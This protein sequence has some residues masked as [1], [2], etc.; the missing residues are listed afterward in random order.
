MF[1]RDRVD[2]RS[3]SLALPPMTLASKL[4]SAPLQAFQQLKQRRR[5][6]RTPAMTGTAPLAYC[7]STSASFVA[8]L[9][10]MVRLCIK[11]TW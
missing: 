10:T 4:S 6:L 9:A 7:V 8:D 11:P 5:Y 2:G 1:C 3:T